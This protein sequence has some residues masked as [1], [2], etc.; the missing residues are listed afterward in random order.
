MQIDSNTIVTA[1]EA[2]QNFSKVARIAEKKGRAVVFKNNRPKY[3]VIDLDVE[4]QIEM[5]ED[6][7]ITFVA[8]RILRE[9]KAAFQELAK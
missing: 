1:T 5:T 3:L 4:P 6:E 7:K 9:H 8:E 2:N